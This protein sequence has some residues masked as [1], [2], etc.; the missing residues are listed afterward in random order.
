MGGEGHDSRRHQRLQTS[1]L[2]VPG[3]RDKKKLAD[4]ALERI[5]FRCLRTC[6]QRRTPGKG[7]PE[8][9][10]PPS[11]M[12]GC[13]QLQRTVLIHGV[14]LIDYRV[15]SAWAIAPLGFADLAVRIDLRCT[16]KFLPTQVPELQLWMTGSHAPHGLPASSTAETRR[17][18]EGLNRP[19]S[20][21]LAPN[22]GLPVLTDRRMR[23]QARK[24]LGTLHADR[25][26]VFDTLVVT[27]P[28]L[29]AGLFHTHLS[30]TV[31]NQTPFHVT[32]I[33]TYL[34]LSVIRIKSD[35]VTI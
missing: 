1:V 2:H 15:W 18:T 7:W 11:P 28:S 29:P 9:G 30:H 12:G 3:Q 24:A 10:Q 34:D 20:A 8:E 16:G 6:F 25:S 26:L 17:N 13:T 5:R 32:E 22:E 21:P 23:P 14:Y 19:L 33:Y 35:L 4:S 27:L 31:P